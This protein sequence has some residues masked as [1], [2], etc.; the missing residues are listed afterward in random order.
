MQSAQ[1]AAAG[2]TAYLNLE[3]G[4]CHGEDAAIRALTEAKVARV[5]VGM[6]H[7]L[8]HLRGTGIAALRSRGIAVGEL[9]PGASGRVCM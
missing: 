1:G 3:T 8:A 6:K 2:A 7:P 9:E 4:D 5:V